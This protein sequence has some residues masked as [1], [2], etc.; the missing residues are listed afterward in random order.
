MA[1]ANQIYLHLPSLSLS[2]KDVT[3]HYLWS[4]YVL[5]RIVQDKMG[6]KINNVC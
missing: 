3:K 4:L 5:N 6:I 2:D 1:T